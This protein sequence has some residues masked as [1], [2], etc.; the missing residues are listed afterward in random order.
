MQVAGE[1]ASAPRSDAFRAVAALARETAGLSPARHADR[2]RAAVATVT[3]PWYC[4]AEPV[5]LT[6][7]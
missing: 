4:C 3:E 6:A 2:I 1:Y 5:E 7:I